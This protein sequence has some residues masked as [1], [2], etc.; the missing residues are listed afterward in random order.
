MEK[1]LIKIFT[2]ICTLC[3]ISCGQNKQTSKATLTFDTSFLTVSNSLGG[4]YFFGKNITTGEDFALVDDLIPSEIELTNGN[5]TFLAVS[6]DGLSDPSK[7]MEGI[8]K[9]SKVDVALNGTEVN[10]RMSLDAATCKNL[11]FG[12]T[13]VRDSNQDLKLSKFSKCGDDVITCSNSTP[14]S[15]KLVLRQKTLDGR[16]EDGLVSRCINDST[17]PGTPEF[18]F[19]HTIKA[20]FNMIPANYKKQRIDFYED[21]A[22]TNLD[23]SFEFSRDPNSSTSF[24]DQTSNWTI[25]DDATYAKINL[26]VPICQSQ[27][28]QNPTPFTTGAENI[29]CNKN[30][31]T[32]MNSNPTLDYKF[33][34][35]I[36]LEG[37]TYSSPLV[38]NALSGNIDG[39]GRK[40]FNGSFDFSGRTDNSGI[41][42][43]YDSPTLERVIKNLSVEDI[44]VI[45]PNSYPSAALFGA[46]SGRV[47]IKELRANKI[48]I[49]TTSSASK[50]GGLIGS[51]TSSTA[52]VN[53]DSWMAKVSN[54]TI[55]ASLCT[56]CSNI[57]AAI[58][59][60]NTSGSSL[61]DIHGLYAEN[62][63]LNVKDSIKVGG[64]LGSI[65]FKNT[66]S[67]LTGKNIK[68][69]NKNTATSSSVNQA[70]G[71]LIGQDESGANSRTLNEVMISDSEIGTSGSELKKAVGVGGILGLS[72]SA[73]GILQ[74]A[75]ANNIKI[76][77]LEDFGISPT[78][79]GIGGIAGKSSIELKDVKFDG[80][81]H[82]DISDAAGIIGGKYAQG[83]SNAKSFGSI[84]CANNCGGIIGKSYNPPVENIE[85]LYSNMNI[86]S[87]GLE[88]GGIFGQLDISDSN[89]VKYLNF[90]GYVEGAS[91]YGCLGGRINLN[92]GSTFNIFSLYTNCTIKS[93]VTAALGISKIH[94]PSGLGNTLIFQGGAYFLGVDESSNKVNFVYQTK[95]GSPLPNIVFVSDDC[96]INSSLDVPSSFSNCGE[97]PDMTDI[98]KTNNLI[99]TSS[100]EFERNVIGEL[101]L[102]KY[103][104]ESQIGG[105]EKLGS[106][107]DPYLI[108]TKLQWNNIEDKEFL[109]NKTFV[110]GNSIDFSGAAF[111]PIGSIANPFR[112]TFIGNGQTLKNIS[113]AEGTTAPLGIFRKLAGSASIND[114]TKYPP[115]DNIKHDL[116]IYNASFT[117]STS[118]AVGTIAGEI[119]DEAS[120]VLIIKNVT[121]L[122]DANSLT[123]EINADS[124]ANSKV[125][126]AIGHSKFYNS[127]STIENI[128][129]KNVNLTALSSSGTFAGGI[130]GYLEG[131]SYTLRKQFFRGSI[132][133]SGLTA[134]GGLF[135]K[136]YPNGGGLISLQELVSTGEINTDV[137]NYTGGIFGDVSSG[138]I[139][140]SDSRVNTTINTTSTTSVGC[141]GGNYAGSI[142]LSQI[143]TT[144]PTLS[145]SLSIYELMPSGFTVTSNKTLTFDGS[146]L[147]ANDIRTSNLADFTSYTQ[148][149]ALIG[150]PWPTFKYEP[151]QLPFLPF[152]KD[153]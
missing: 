1:K 40:I 34:S 55:D 98:T 113:A 26:L 141:L 13:Q 137:S 90:D 75:V 116:Y 135:G 112:G 16:I 101:R 84:N 118:S 91:D 94:D 79:L 114:T 4:V 149:E 129:V 127:G 3:L 130:I 41:F 144:C 88:V 70:I 134:T 28:G 92:S 54:I 81:I 50:I 27:V 99:T 110:L 102:T 64:L 21:A 138:V 48:T 106:I 131:N 125:G 83:I 142:S 60:F 45:T 80:E 151:G 123:N 96:L 61:T 29:I 140:I 121:I 145:G 109:M 73:S 14:L 117:S 46:I 77:A 104:N 17:A 139:S 143:Y 36:N 71:G 126:G 122:G 38:T 66:F 32:F 93:G 8:M 11:A 6:W 89:Q 51:Y 49:T 153:I 20:F 42:A 133:T 119:D 128:K 107:I 31:F 74:N 23:Y 132:D 146:S 18:E 57:G 148:I 47:Q 63:Y 85:N 69:E 15:M 35:D 97:A 120:E 105:L 150:S 7:K 65:N 100:N 56:I 33:L 58:G 115:I 86:T 76:H 44:T 67:K 30:Q 62:I 124:I 152:E 103:L 87:S 147:T 19:S 22:C 82:T 25:V 43:S 9:C 111:N 53:F 72:T 52:T 78:P 12:P 59:F 68:I 136:I 39:N 24:F 37:N 10:I 95:S 108:S 2:I 5:W